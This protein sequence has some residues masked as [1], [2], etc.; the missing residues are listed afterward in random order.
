MLEVLHEAM[1]SLPESYQQVLTL[2]Y[3]GGMDGTEIAEFLGMS[4]SAIWQRLSRARASLKKEILDMISETYE[5]NRLR[6][7]FT[8][9]VLEM[10]KRIGIDP[11]PPR[12]LPWGFSIATGI[13]IAV[14][15]IGMRF[16]LSNTEYYTSLSSL[17]AIPEAQDIGELP[18]DVV[19]ASDVSVISGN[20]S[21]GDNSGDMHPDLQAFFMAPQG[22]GDTWTEKADMPT[23]RS[24]LSACTVNG[25]IYAI[26]GYGQGGLL[27][28]VE[29]YDP[30]TDKW[31][32]KADMPTARYYLAT[33]EANGKIYAIGGGLDEN[34]MDFSAVEE[35][36]P[37]KDEWTK[38]AD[39]LTARHWLSAS[40]VNGKIYAIGGLVGNPMHHLSTVEEYDPA[41]DKWTKKA[42]LPRKLHTIS[43]SVVNGKIYG[44]AGVDN[45]IIIQTVYEYDP[46]ID[47]WTAKA[48]MPTKR[49]RVCTSVVNK[50]IYAVGG[51]DELF[52][53]NPGAKAVPTVEEYD[54]VADKWTAKTDMPMPR[55][56]H[57]CS[58]VDG[59]IYVFGGW[60][61][62]GGEDVASS[63]LE[64]DT[65]FS[66]EKVDPE[67][68]LPT[69]WGDV[70]TVMEK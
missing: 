4:P 15:G 34:D 8:F 54:P 23:A 3:L 29:E 41:E 70:R 45:G 39:M 37:V 21:A 57:A 58:A 61:N 42:S 44:F 27:H 5:Q 28:T 12:A 40:F 22:Q 17:S 59:K 51:L 65:G 18:V 25:K 19:N 26:G 66:G 43:T 62:D 16:N 10:V 55:S 20:Q 24:G 31:T 50:R 53:N 68:K 30:K 63:V 46:L 2:H 11:V 52:L 48:N 6:A 13:I 56:D 7:G 36:D 60:R 38:K 1:D 35:Y 32:R 69:T 64:Y 47:K 49:W 9:R 33:C 14:L 67:G